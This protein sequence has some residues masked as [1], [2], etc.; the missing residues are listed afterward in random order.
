MKE[1]LLQEKNCVH[2]KNYLSSSVEGVERSSSLATKGEVPALLVALS[3]EGFGGD[4][5]DVL[6]SLEEFERL[7]I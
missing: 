1:I 5:A 4:I 2:G 6:S 7:D 3:I